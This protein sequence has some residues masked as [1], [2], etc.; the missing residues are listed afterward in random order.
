LNRALLVAALL[1]VAV[2][3]DAA[4]PLRCAQG[5]VAK[6]RAH[7]T[8]KLRADWCE[9]V[10]TGKPH[11]TYR[12]SSPDGQL[13][14]INEY[15][16]GQRV[17]HRITQH[18]IRMMIAELNAEFERTGENSV[19]TLV[20]EH[21][22]RVD[23]VMAGAKPDDLRGNFKEHM[24]EKGTPCQLLSMEGADIRTLQM[25]AMNEKQRTLASATFV[26]KDCDKAK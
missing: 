8:T 17:S 9:D 4:E 26:R 5:T 25:F 22:I 24:M 23:I 6:S 1:A 15:R 13:V 19:I 11:G 20:D 14:V 16:Q 7:P 2:D 12:F 3:G 21:S 18:G 10:K